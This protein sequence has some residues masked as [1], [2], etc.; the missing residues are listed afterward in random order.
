MARLPVLGIRV[1]RCPGAGLRGGSGEVEEVGKVTGGR[2]S[3]VVGLG[4]VGFG[5]VGFGS[6]VSVVSP[7]RARLPTIPLG[8]LSGEDSPLYFDVAAADTFT[9]MTFCPVQRSV[10]FGFPLG[11]GDSRGLVAAACSGW[12]GGAGEAGGITAGLTGRA[13]DGRSA[14]WCE[15]CG[16]ACPPFAAE[17]EVAGRF[18]GLFAR[19]F[20]GWMSGLPPAAACCPPMNPISS[21]S[22][23]LSAALLGGRITVTVVFDP[24]PGAPSGG[25][26]L[27]KVSCRCGGF[28]AA[29]R[30]GRDTRPF[31][32]LGPGEGTVFGAGA[33]SAVHDLRTATGFGEIRGGEGLA[34]LPAAGCHRSST[35]A[36]FAGTARDLSSEG[37]SYAICDVLLTMFWTKPLP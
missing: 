11:V 33:G 34:V 24:R 14:G 36:F 16:G 20:V 32:T 10:T 19:S 18:F 25:I 4:L 1:W 5:L 2:D 9:P 17:A 23:T 8:R 27:T 35:D 28:A 7:G 30:P 15:D 12:D 22:G 31:S 21:T 26:F 37:C 13:S 6:R 3:E 29:A